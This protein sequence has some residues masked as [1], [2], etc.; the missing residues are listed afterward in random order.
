MLYF[1]VGV[2]WSFVVFVG[3]AYVMKDSLVK[4]KEIKTI[5][6]IKN[7][8][9]KNIVVKTRKEAEDIMR[10]LESFV[11]EK[12]AATIANLYSEAN[13]SAK[14]LDLYNKYGWSDLTDYN[15]IKISDDYYIL[16]LPK[17][18]DIV[19]KPVENDIKM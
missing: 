5:D 12:G 14:N 9:S 18:I 15:I 10:K 3:L 17:P 7:D 2:I 19:N 13:W 6:D 1:F 4:E 16:N 8:K 11:R